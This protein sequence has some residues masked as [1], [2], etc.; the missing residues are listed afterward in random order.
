[1]FEQ[2]VLRPAPVRGW[3][4]TLGFAGEVLVVACVMAAPLIW[5]QLLPQA[6]SMTW[7]SAP[8]PPP[9]PL[10]Q[11]PLP[12]V[13]PTRPWQPQ[14]AVLYQQTRDR[15]LSVRLDEPPPPVGDVVGGTAAG[16]SD[17][18]LN[19]A[20]DSITRPAAPKPIVEAAPTVPKPA[21][22]SPTPQ[23]RI[24]GAVQAAR[25]VHRVDPVYP[26]MARQMR[27]AG[28]VELAGVIGTDG[29]IRE[30]SVTSGHPFLVQAAL[31]AVRQWAYRPTLLGGQPVEVI[32]TITVTFRLS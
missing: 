20:I 28:T 22:K 31:E 1:M 21:T 9:P 18:G 19:A 3:A 27:I 26:A 6:A 25:L 16:N 24:G 14:S 8:A 29:R 13:R 12:H 30:V 23:I 11:A 17:L 32:T 5:P 10:K 15:I 2:A 7:I 4:V